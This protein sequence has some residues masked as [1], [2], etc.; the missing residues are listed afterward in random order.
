MIRKV[1]I[2][3]GIIWGIA[4]IIPLFTGNPQQA[5]ETF[6][7]PVTS[8]WGGLKAIVTFVQNLKQQ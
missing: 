8:V 5:A 6:M 2:V 1:L 7:W 3:A 4:V